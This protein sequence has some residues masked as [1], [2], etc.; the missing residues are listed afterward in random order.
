MHVD[1]PEI[2][3]FDD[4]EGF[5]WPMQ[6]VGFGAGPEVPMTADATLYQE[7]DGMTRHT[8]EACRRVEHFAEQGFRQTVRDRGGPLGRL[9]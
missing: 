9:C 2:S 8:E 5:L 6:A 4:I 3:G 1:L 7:N